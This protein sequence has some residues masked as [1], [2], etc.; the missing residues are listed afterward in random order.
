MEA[1]GANPISL[2]GTATFYVGGTLTVAASR[3]ER[4]ARQRLPRTLRRRS[5][6][7]LPADRC[8]I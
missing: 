6:A 8:A 4:R 3:S 5:K 7:A 2:A 1:G